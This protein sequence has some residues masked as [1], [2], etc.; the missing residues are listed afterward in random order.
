MENGLAK[1]LA[2]LKAAGYAQ[3]LK[4]YMSKCTRSGEMRCLESE[5]STFLGT[6]FFPPMMERRVDLPAPLPLQAAVL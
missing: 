2:I 6:I 3:E 4:T 1:N 5:E